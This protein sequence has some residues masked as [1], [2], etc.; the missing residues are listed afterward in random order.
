MGLRSLLARDLIHKAAEDAVA[1]MQPHLDRLQQIIEA[2][3]AIFPDG[4]LDP[5]EAMWRAVGHSKRD[6][7]ELTQ[8]EMIEACFRLYRE[9]PLG[10][11]IPEL[12]RDF[13][14]GDGITWSARNP[15]VEELVQEFWDDS[16]ND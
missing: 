5:D 6:L 14:V 15:N 1:E 2:S 3:D 12:T 9:T 4:R 7:S 16:V 13:I 10:H 11:R 8:T